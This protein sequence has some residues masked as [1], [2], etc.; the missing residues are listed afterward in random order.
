MAKN[1]GTPAFLS[2][3]A[4]LLLKKYCNHIVAIISHAEVFPYPEIGNEELQELKQL[5]AP[6]EKFFSEE[7][8]SAKIDREAKIPPET[9]NGLKELGLFGIMIPEEYGGLGLSNTMYARLAEIISLDG[10]IAVTLATH[11]ALAL[12]VKVK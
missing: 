2:D 1:I 5:V 4:P 3:N 12:K 10:S 9:L 8:D 11:Q 6:V 7:V